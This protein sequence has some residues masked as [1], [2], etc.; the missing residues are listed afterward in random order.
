M[1][2]VQI[3]GVWASY[4]C[5]NWSGGLLKLF[6]CA[7]TLEK[8]AAP[9]LGGHMRSGKQRR[10]SALPPNIGYVQRFKYE[11]FTMS[12]KWTFIC[13]F[14]NL[15]KVA[16]WVSFEPC[17]C[18]CV[19]VGV[20]FSRCTIFSTSFT[21][22]YLIKSQWNKNTSLS[23]QLNHIKTYLSC[24]LFFCCFQKLWFLCSKTIEALLSILTFSNLERAASPFRSVHKW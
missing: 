19:S 14:E 13:N 7:R 17:R 20:L 23:T 4:A 2:T 11:I 6:A 15:S 24:V 9:E 18:V 12:I 1:P 5:I 22:S 10:A 16:L 8:E 3:C 21:S